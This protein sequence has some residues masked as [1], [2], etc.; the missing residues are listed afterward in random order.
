MGMGM[1]EDVW[2]EVKLARELRKMGIDMVSE[3]ERGGLTS[4]RSNQHP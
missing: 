4:G 1:G 2:D 3:S